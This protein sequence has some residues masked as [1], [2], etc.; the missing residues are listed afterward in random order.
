MDRFN[1]RSAPV[2]AIPARNALT[3]KVHHDLL[4]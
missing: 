4:D 1:D 2:N 3:K